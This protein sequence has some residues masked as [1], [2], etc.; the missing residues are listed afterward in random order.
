MSTTSCIYHIVINTYKR[1][2]TIREESKKSLYA[3]IYGILKEKNCFVHRIN[4]IPNHVH[5]LMDLHPSI[6]LAD[7]MKNLKQ[8]SSL[9]MKRNGLFPEWE[10]WGKEYFAFS[11]SKEDIDVV[12]QY[13]MN[14]E[15]HHS[16]NSFED[17]M[18]KIVDDE[19]FR[20]D[21]YLLT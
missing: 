2:M 1:E 17:E 3:Y 16:S 14:Q 12:K 9:W 13:I 6:S 10:G 8:S 19:G 20:W 4:G 18:R 5:I 7:L 15:N 11:K 21:D